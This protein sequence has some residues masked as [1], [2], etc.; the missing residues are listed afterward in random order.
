MIVCDISNPA[1]W[2]RHG[3]FDLPALVDLHLADGHAYM[4]VEGGLLA[5]KFTELPYFRSIVRTADKIVLNWNDL[6]GLRLQSTPSLTNPDWT[7]VPGS[8]GTN[9]M[10]LAL[11]AGHQFFRLVQPA[12]P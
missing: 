1:N 8:V 4:A 7:D 11:G 3:G 6:P 9:Q 10:Q 5:Y 2:I 12:T